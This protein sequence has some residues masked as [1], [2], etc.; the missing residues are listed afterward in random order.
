[1]P[2]STPADMLVAQEKLNVPLPGVQEE[3]VRRDIMSRMIFDSSSAPKHRLAAESERRPA[4]STI[5]PPMVEGLGSTK[6]HSISDENRGSRRSAELPCNKR[7]GPKIYS[8]QMIYGPVPGWEK[9]G[10]SKDPLYCLI[11]WIDLLLPA[12]GNHGSR[13]SFEEAKP[14]REWN[15]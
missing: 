8:D 4:F 1:M 12:S 9:K 2:E 3:E 15:F 11:P 6:Q 14:L 5:K 7:Q 13:E 10:C